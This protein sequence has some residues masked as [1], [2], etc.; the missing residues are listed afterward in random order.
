M[1]D[2]DLMEWTLEDFG[3]PYPIYRRFRERAPVQRGADDAWYVFGYPQVRQ[4]LLSRDLGHGADRP[5]PPGCPAMAETARNW[6]V[7]M[8]PPRH[9]ALRRAISG[10]FLPRAVAAGRPRITRIADQ[11]IAELK[12]RSSFDLITDF[13][14]PYAVTVVLELLGVPE[15][16][17]R[18]L[19]E[20]MDWLRQAALLPIK[21][22]PPP[23]LGLAD[24]GAI[25]LVEG[26]GELIRQHRD[27]ADPGLIP[28]L[29][30]AGREPRGRWSDED[31]AH[32]CVS[33][34]SAG[35]E[36]VAGMLGKAVLALHRHPE[37]RQQLRSDPLRVIDELTRYDGPVQVISRAACR[38][39]QLGGHQIRRDEVVLLMLGAAN[40][41]PGTFDLPDS[42]RPG[43]SGPHLGFGIGAHYCLGVHLARMELDVGLTALLTAFPR[44]WVAEESLRH[45]HY[46]AFHGPR[47][48]R[49]YPQ[50]EGGTS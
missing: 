44:M 5:E 30:R 6:P 33:L 31:L 42:P 20:R 12:T 11:L 21:D 50:N 34:L 41:D 7:F 43:R 3:D 45:H 16:Q 8:N 24:Q 39:T 9:T 19:H 40:R 35:Y 38:D 13:A 2:F 28:R 47:Q 23:N 27:S 32:A 26:F 15:R 29:A 18:W 36:T 25:A 37:L 4:A 14:V 22:M 17:R 49:I 46:R 10:P 48:L 1:T